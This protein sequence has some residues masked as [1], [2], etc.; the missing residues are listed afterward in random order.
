MNLFHLKIKKFR[1]KQRKSPKKQNFRIFQ[2]KIFRKK[3]FEVLTKIAIFR[4]K[5]ISHKDLLDK[6][7]SQTIRKFHFKMY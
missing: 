3:K 5:W 6:E 1:R 2:A 4:Q 7:S